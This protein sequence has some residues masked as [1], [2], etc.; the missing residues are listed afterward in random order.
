MPSWVATRRASVGKTVHVAVWGWVVTGPGAARG[1]D[2]GV[3]GG[4]GIG[5]IFRKG[6][7]VRK[8][9]EAQI[10]DALWEETQIFLAERDAEEQAARGADQA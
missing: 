2:V 8:V 10:V 4:R 7:V 6:E 9:P 5:L 1:A 3:A